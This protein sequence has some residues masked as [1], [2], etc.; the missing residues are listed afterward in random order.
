MVGDARL[1]LGQRRR[2]L[3]RALAA[4][5]A[6]RPAGLKTQKNYGCIEAPRRIWIG[7]VDRV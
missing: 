5:L 3:T 7:R 2:S 4:A 1:K 6:T